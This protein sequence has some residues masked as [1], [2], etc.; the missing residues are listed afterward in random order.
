MTLYMRLLPSLYL[1]LL[2]LLAKSVMV[3]NAFLHSTLYKIQKLNILCGFVCVCVC[4]CVCVLVCWMEILGVC[5]CVSVC[6]RHYLPLKRRK[7]KELK[8]SLPTSSGDEMSQ[9]YNNT[10]LT[11]KWRTGSI[12][13]TREWFSL[14]GLRCGEKF[15]SVF[16]KEK[17]HGPPL[18]R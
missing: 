2:L 8:I 7:V 15:I 17:T 5:E 16:L 9:C 6:H 18:I 12:K 1:S 11:A 3:S 14:F 4:V 13:Y 10:C